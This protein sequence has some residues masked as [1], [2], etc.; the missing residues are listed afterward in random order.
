MRTITRGV[1]LLTTVIAVGV[2]A[3][4]A[5]ASAPPVAPS[6]TKLLG[7]RI[8]VGFDGLQAS[9]SLLSAVRQGRI[10]SVILFAYNIG[11][12]AQLRA[13]TG[14]LQNAARSGGNPPVL[15]A[16]DQEGGQIK[17]L[18]SG[19][20]YLSPP[21]MTSTGNPTAAF[22]QGRA[23]ASYLKG[24][25]VNWDLAP[26]LD[27]P[28]FGGAFI[29]QEGRAFSFNATR[30]ATYGT[31]FALGLQRNR[32]AA[33]GKHFPGV[34]TAG[35]DTDF[36][37]DRLFPGPIT[38]GNALL[39]Y[40]TLIPRGLD[41]VMLSTAAYPAHDASGTPA[42]LSVPIIQGLLRGRLHFQGVAITDALFSPTGYDEATAG[43]VA[44]RAGADVLLYTDSAPG[45]LD[46]L[47][48]DLKSGRLSRGGALASYRRIVALKR[49][50]G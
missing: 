30:V 42:A 11:S 38:W 32:A 19:P 37:L 12:R 25:G 10:G 34:G 20:P 4:A 15:I 36:L 27:V 21:Q 7:Q 3:A 35:V 5:A 26:V 29:W 1:V 16:I 45:V 40:K 41:S 28:T 39:P 18:A 14:S 50:V 49:K 31:Q 47:Q 17:R 2:A 9:P 6:D 43:R 33:T 46:G 22:N 48:S 13:L 8:M 44:A 24:L 23:T